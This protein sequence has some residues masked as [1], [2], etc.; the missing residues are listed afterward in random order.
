MLV[1]HNPDKQ[2]DLLHPTK[3]LVGQEITITKDRMLFLKAD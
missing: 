2:Q 3:T 1:T